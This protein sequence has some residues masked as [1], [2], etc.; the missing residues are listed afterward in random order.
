MLVLVAIDFYNTENVHS[1]VTNILQNIFFCVEQK[2]K[3]LTGLEQ[4]VDDQINDRTC[5]TLFFINIHCIKLSKFQYIQN[6]I[7]VN[8][9]FSSVMYVPIFSIAHEQAVLIAQLLSI[10]IYII[11]FTQS[12]ITTSST[13][14]HNGKQQNYIIY[15]T[16][17]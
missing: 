4:L 12:H 7:S 17:S 11:V 10:I 15:Q 13:L 14:Q 9:K 5:W 1:L 8:R 3:T 2:I 16:L 6:C